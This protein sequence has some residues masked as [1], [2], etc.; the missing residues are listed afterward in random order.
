M[1][2]DVS[3]VA[4]EAQLAKLVHEVT[5]AGACGADHLG[6]RFL[7]DVRTDQL[8]AAFLPEIG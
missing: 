1:N 8:R 5:D 3:V 7:T 6:Q 2:F 4:D